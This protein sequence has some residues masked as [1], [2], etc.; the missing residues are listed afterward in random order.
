VTEENGN[1]S[2]SASLR[3]RFRALSTT[4]AG[5]VD[6]WLLIAGAVIAPL[7]VLLILLGWVGAARTPFVFEQLPYVISGGLLGLALVFIGGFVYFTYWQTRAVRESRQQQQELLA[8]LD[9][10]VVL[11]ANDAPVAS[12]ERLVTTAKGAM[13]HRPECPVAQRSGKLKTVRGDERGLRPCGICNP[14][15]VT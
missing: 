5:S 4:R 13:Y 14:V 1:G 3:D 12:A 2:S 6:R 8:K 15:A 11:L 7:G 9:Q 10:I